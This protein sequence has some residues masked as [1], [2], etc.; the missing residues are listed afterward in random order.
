MT[1]FLDHLIC[2]RLG[3]SGHPSGYLIVNILNSNKNIWFQNNQEVGGHYSWISEIVKK[4]FRK[5]KGLFLHIW[6]SNKKHSTF[7]IMVCMSSRYK[8]VFPLAQLERLLCRLHKNQTSVPSF[9]F[10]SFL[11]S[12]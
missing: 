3:K 5:I 2:Q 9:S 4:S 7:K 8:W 6:N 10:S 11:F 1:Y 12:F